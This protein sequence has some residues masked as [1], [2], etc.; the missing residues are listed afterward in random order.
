MEQ[1][2]YEYNRPCTCNQFLNFCVKPL[3]IP[4]ML[5]VGFSIGIIVYIPK[6]AA[7][8]A[9]NNDVLPI[10]CPCKSAID[11]VPGSCYHQCGR[12]CRRYY[13][14]YKMTFAINCSSN[15]VYK[16][17]S[18]SPDIATCETIGQA[19]CDTQ[20]FTYGFYGVNHTEFRTEG[21]TNTASEVIIVFAVFIGFSR[22]LFI[23]CL[24][25]GWGD[26][27]EDNRKVKQEIAVAASRKKLAAFQN[28]MDSTPINTNSTYYQAALQNAEQRRLATQHQIARVAVN[29][30]N[31]EAQR[32]ARQSQMDNLD[33]ENNNAS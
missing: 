27:D 21:K 25:H 29:N 2:K 3:I 11:P 16:Y 30:Q 14:C 23:A 6:Q 18:C 9:Y 28:T 4:V 15:F 19:E 10:A 32:H 5:I 33:I 8:N 20:L 12:N 17:S 26:Y 31:L 1:K 24:C 13:T 7:I 22:M